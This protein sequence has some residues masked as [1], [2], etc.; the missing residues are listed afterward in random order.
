MTHS[1]F[2]RQISRRE[3]NV[4]AKFH[5]AEFEK[6]YST[7]RATMTR[8]GSLRRVPWHIERISSPSFTTGSRSLRRMSWREMKFTNVP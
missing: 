7:M 6:Q 1:E 5:D 3:A 2:L 8:S 4:S